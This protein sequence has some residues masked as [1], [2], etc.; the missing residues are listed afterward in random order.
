[1]LQYEGSQSFNLL[2][3]CP[4]GSTTQARQIAEA[5]CSLQFVR[6]TMLSHADW[7]NLISHEPSPL[8]LKDPAQLLE[9]DLVPSDLD[10]I[11]VPEGLRHKMRD[12]D[13]RLE[14]VYELHQQTI[15]KIKT[16]MAEYHN[17][18]MA[19]AEAK[20]RV[21]SRKKDYG[22]ALHMWIAR[23]AEKGLLEEVLEV[24]Q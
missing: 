7:A 5:A 24:T 19:I 8:D 23:L 17:R 14:D 22:S 11:E 1:M 3:L 9:Y 16:A 13:L 20:Q 6:E 18:S 21:M 2:A 10:Q 4:T 15:I 12:P